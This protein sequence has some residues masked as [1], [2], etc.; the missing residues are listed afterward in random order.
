MPSM[1]DERARHE[2]L[3]RAE[4]LTPDAPARWGKFNCPGMMAHV[5]D[6]MRMALG[7]IHPPLRKSALRLFPLKQLIIYVFPFPKGAPTASSLLARCDG[8]AFQDEVQA[9]RQILQRLAARAGDT[10]WPAH[11]AFGPMS[12]RD[13]GALGY[14]HVDHHFTQFGV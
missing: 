9:F 7:E 3:A 8:A 2:L 6:A 1:W 10:T 13:W 12:R 5:N 11:P 14:K 4:R